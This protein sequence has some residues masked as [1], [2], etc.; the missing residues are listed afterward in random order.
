[1]TREENRPKETRT[2]RRP[3]E[4]PQD[5]TL[6]PA[7]LKI[8][9]YLKITN[10]HQSLAHK[11]VPLYHSAICRIT[12][13]QIR[14]PVKNTINYLPSAGVSKNFT[15]KLEV[16]LSVSIFEPHNFGGYADN[17]GIQEQLMGY[18]ADV[19]GNSSYEN[20]SPSL[21]FSL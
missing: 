6:I 8:P 9:V 19:Y 20:I 15:S 18:K 10:R 21:K 1:M 14:T 7:Y 13:M 4:E 16:F 2:E 12:G 3:E 11:S 17:T 5:C